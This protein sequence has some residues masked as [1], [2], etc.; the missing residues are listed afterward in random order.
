MSR[1]EYFWQR[2]TQVLNFVFA[3]PLALAF[4]RSLCSQVVVTWHVHRHFDATSEQLENPRSLSAATGQ[5]EQLE[6][7]RWNR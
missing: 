4:S 3:I 2:N 7:A 5:R 6:A 1:F